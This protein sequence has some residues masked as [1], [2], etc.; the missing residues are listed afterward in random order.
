[1]SSLLHVG[2]ALRE[3]LD[4][5]VES[6]E[7]RVRRLE[8][9]DRVG[10]V[11]HRDDEARRERPHG[12]GRRGPAVG[13][14][15]ADGHEQHVDAADRVALL[16]PQRPLAEV[17][18]VAEAHAVEGE[19]EDGVRAARGAGDIVVL[20]SDGDDLTDGRLQPPGSRAQ[21]H[22]RAADDLDRIVVAVFVRH[23][24]EIRCR[25]LDRWVI[26]LD[27]ARSRRGHVAE[28]IDEDG[29]LAEEQERRLAVPADAHDEMMTEI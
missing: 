24:H 10:A 15:A 18:E 25:A 11:V 26:E 17:A 3:P 2:F 9:V 7:E 6:R 14:T 20:G 29:P 22:R 16:R 27:P 4:S 12:I 19:A 8:E 21:H 23:Q 5:S 13:R 1:L 28:R